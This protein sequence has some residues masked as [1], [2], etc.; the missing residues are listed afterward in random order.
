MHYVGCTD[1]V[2]ASRVRGYPPTWSQTHQFAGQASSGRGSVTATPGR[3]LYTAVSTMIARWRR[4]LR[5]IAALSYRAIAENVRASQQGGATGARARG[6]S[7][8]TA[9]TGDSGG[10]S[11]RSAIGAPVRIR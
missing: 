5:R 3:R 7:R 8:A 2:S 10:A 9:G 1:P 11:W 6:R 4:N